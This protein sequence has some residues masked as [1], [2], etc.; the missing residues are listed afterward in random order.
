MKTVALIVSALAACA[1]SP[2]GHASVCET[3]Y[4]PIN[5]DTAYAMDN[6]AGTAT[7]VRTGLV[8]KRC[9]EGFTWNGTTCTGTR[10]LLNWQ[11]SLALAEATTFANADDWRLPNL[12]EILSL[13]ETCR[14]DPAVNVTVFPLTP[15]AVDDQFAFWSSSPV[16]TTTDQAWFVRSGR[17][18]TGE[19][20]RTLTK[21]VRLVR[22]GG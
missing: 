2:S 10:A 12:K 21:L 16:V 15:T 6:V 17:G 5:P 9:V 4:L 1:S 20:A 11:Q 18:D 14:M 19:G 13:A 3:G 8:W 22:G 7:D